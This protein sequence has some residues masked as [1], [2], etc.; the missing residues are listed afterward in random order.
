MSGLSLNSGSSLYWY[1]ESCFDAPEYRGRHLPCRLGR[2]YFGRST[3]E[4]EFEYT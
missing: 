3:G 2:C 1:T 4:R